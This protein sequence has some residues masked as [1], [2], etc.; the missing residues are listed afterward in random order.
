MKWLYYRLIYRP[1]MRLAHRH[2]WH[3]MKHVNLHPPL[4]GFPDGFLRCEW[5][6]IHSDVPYSMRAKRVE[7]MMKAK[8]AGGE[9]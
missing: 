4:T 9:G 2:G 3:R 1:L 7:A 6:G 5:C 8:A